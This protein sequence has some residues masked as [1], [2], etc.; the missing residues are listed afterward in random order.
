MK[1]QLANR[2]IIRE[3]ES[4]DEAYQFIDQW[5]LSCLVLNLPSDDAFYIADKFTAHA[6]SV[7]DKHLAQQ[8][9]PTLVLH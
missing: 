9:L 7:V 6:I 5:L 8:S 3:V 1:I 2:M 4:T